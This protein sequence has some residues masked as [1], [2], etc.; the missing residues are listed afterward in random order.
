MRFHPPPVKPY[1]TLLPSG[2]KTSELRASE[3]EQLS[4]VVD[5]KL[6]SLAPQ[7]VKLSSSSW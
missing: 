5:Q 7:G 2:L 3:A 6:A 4:R 1:L